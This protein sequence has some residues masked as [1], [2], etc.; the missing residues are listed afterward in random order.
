M[1]KIVGSRERALE[2]RDSIEL[3]SNKWRIAILHLLS[4]G[5]LRTGELQR[6]LDD[7]SP[8][9]LTQSLRSMERDGLIERKIFPVVPPRVEYG[10]T[11]MG[12]SVLTPLREL[13]HWARA[14][15]AKRDAARRRFDSAAPDAAS[16]AARRRA[17]VPPN[18]GA[19][20]GRRA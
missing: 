14:N 17:A 12:A 15:R 6:G 10:V 7:I 2:S 9:V 18:G 4:A 5:T 11:E 1:P 13:C 8:K 20:P 16:S 19:S 3:L